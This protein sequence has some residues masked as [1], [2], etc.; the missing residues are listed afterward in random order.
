MARPLRLQFPGAL[1]H[2]TARGNDRKAIY[3]ADSDRKQFLFLLAHAIDRYVLIL[4][5]YVLMGNHYHLLLETREANLSL[6]LRHLNGLYTTYFNRT[7]HRVGH[8]FQGRYKAILVEKESYLLELSRYIHLNPLRSRMKER[9]NSYPWSSY[10]DYIGRRQAPDWLTRKE[11]LSYFGGS[12]PEEGYRRFVEEGI[13]DG[14]ETPWERVFAQVG[15]GGS[16]FIRRL[17]KRVQGG[18][19]RE[20]PSRR[21][22]EKRPSWSVIEKAVK[23]AIPELDRLK[24]GRRSD[25]SRAVLF[26]LGR[27]RGGMSLKELAGRFGVEES[28][29]SRA[30]GRVSRLRL[31]DSLWDRIVRKIE[32]NI[33]S[34][35]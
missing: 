28:T 9:L 7:Y 5:A 1:Y 13:R 12:R 11:V 19:N 16:E 32:R 18:R 26:Y 27:E 25:P 31:E 10:L 29:V 2:I 33:E 8:L 30:A 14:V 20:V 22:L 3:R 34:N 17:Q 15:L 35:I 23:N 4:H 6:A 21:R 24:S